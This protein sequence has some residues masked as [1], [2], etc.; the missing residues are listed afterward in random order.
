M[1]AIRI[2]DEN[3][4]KKLN[5]LYD[6]IKSQYGN[7]RNNF[8]CDCL[9]RGSERIAEEIYFQ[10]SGKQRKKDE[11]SEKINESLTT[12]MDL[13]ISLYAKMEAVI[14]M[15]ASNQEML[16]G[17]SEE[18]PKLT[19]MIKQGFYDKPPSR[20]EKL[21]NDTLKTYGVT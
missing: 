19:S 1:C 14:A 7:V 2:K 16:I 6:K 15:V 12:I 11:V 10:T 5:C 18:A 8:L 20:I 21:V 4:L 13:V 9:N 3:A 17:L